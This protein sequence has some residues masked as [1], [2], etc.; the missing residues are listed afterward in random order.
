MNNGTFMKPSGTINS[1]SPK[2]ASLESG[3]GIG[4]NSGVGR[5]RCYGIPPINIESFGLFD[6]AMLDFF[7]R[8]ALWHVSEKI[9]VKILKAKEFSKRSGRE[10]TFETEKLG[11]KIL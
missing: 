4:R 1:I 10:N 5:N 7:D 8:S 2:I 3:T 6:R 11:T 9:K